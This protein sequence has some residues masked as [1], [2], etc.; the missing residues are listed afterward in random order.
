LNFKE[1]TIILQ[2]CIFLE[3][4]KYYVRE[5][6]INEGI[7]FIIKLSQEIGSS[8]RG[9]KRAKKSLLPSQ[10]PNENLEKN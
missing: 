8:V 5:K 7:K 1:V 2:N 10:R 6:N 3:V 9:R 4:N